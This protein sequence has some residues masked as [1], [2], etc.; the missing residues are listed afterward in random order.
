[1]TSPFERVILRWCGPE[2]MGFCQF[3]FPFMLSSAI[4]YGL[5]RKSKIMGEEGTEVVNATIALVASFM[6]WAYP[7]IVGID[8]T[9][10]MTAFF[11][12][13]FVVAL[14]TI[15]GISIASM[16][17]PK[18]Q[19]LFEKNKSI[20][21]L[22]VFVFLVVGILLVFTSGL[23]EVFGGGVS[24]SPQISE[25]VM[26]IGVLAIMLLTIF[27]IVRGSTPKA[28]PAKGGGG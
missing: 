18:I 17:H 5:L 7:V 16:A 8:I 11:M 20:P 4:F 9:E 14:F 23:W 27:F 13:G 21:I 12:Q 10:A 15:M 1:L 2:G 24:L 3:L 22:F 26:S 6:I 28:A 25:T 19:D